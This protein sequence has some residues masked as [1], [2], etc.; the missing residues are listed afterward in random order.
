MLLTEYDEEKVHRM[1]FRD[2]ERKGRAE[3]ERKGR[4]EGRV[5]GRVEG[6]ARDVSIINELY[7]AGELSEEIRNKIINSFRESD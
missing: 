6:R 5:E 1:F 2:G 7:E 4:A 3:G